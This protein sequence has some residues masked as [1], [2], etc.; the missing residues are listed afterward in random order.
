[1][2]AKALTYTWWFDGPMVGSLRMVD[3][4]VLCYCFLGG[5]EY[6]LWPLEA[7]EAELGE[8]GE[9]PLGRLSWSDVD[10]SGVERALVG[11]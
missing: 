6:G 5:D 3:G 9:P 11:A 2:K 1:M 10:W 4:R 7:L 8:D